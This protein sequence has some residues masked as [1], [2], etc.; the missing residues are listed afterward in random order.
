MMAVDVSALIVAY[1][2]RAGSR[3]SV[4][5]IRP[6]AMPHSA[7]RTAASGAANRTA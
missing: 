1:S 5:P 6:N 4:S 2:A 3:Q 7:T